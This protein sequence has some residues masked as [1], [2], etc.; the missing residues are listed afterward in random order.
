MSNT[1]LDNIQDKVAIV[2]GSSRGI[3]K[4]IAIELA[5]KGIKVMIN[6]RHDQTCQDVVKEIETFG[7]CA[8]WFVCDLSIS[9]EAS[10]L[11][12]ETIKEFGRIDILV[13]NAGIN[14]SYIPVQYVALNSFDEIFNTNCKAPLIL[15]KE[16]FPY[17]KETNGTI[18][19]VSSITGIRPAKYCS[20]Y[21]MTKAALISL[22]KSLALEWGKY[23]IRSNSISPGWVDTKLTQKEIGNINIDTYK[24][25]L[26]T[27][28]LGV[29]A[30]TNEIAQLVVFLSSDKATYI[31]GS[32]FI[33]DGGITMI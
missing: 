16:C 25:I 31:N 11:I 24:E 8:R 14:N 5:R 26:K 7:G 18:I 20:L 23:G 15:A 22:T 9:S 2:T 3:G 27:I 1:L 28:P 4:A 29:V 17:L 32:N 21:S 30:N 19:N 12:K 13:N 33:I 10:S 6:G